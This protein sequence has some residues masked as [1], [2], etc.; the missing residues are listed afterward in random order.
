[1]HGSQGLYRNQ[2]FALVDGPNNSRKVCIEDTRVVSGKTEDGRDRKSTRTVSV[3]PGG[4]VP[5]CETSGARARGRGKDERPRDAIETE[6][7]RRHS[8]NRQP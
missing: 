2:G 5:Q 8:Y 1:M 7:D 3:L 4:G 6:F